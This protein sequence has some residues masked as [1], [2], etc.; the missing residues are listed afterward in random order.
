MK[1]V[2]VIKFNKDLENREIPMPEVGS[3]DVLIKVRAAGICHSDIHQSEGVRDINL[4]YSPGHEIA[5]E[6][7]GLG[8]NVSE[9]QIGQRVC[10]HYVTS[11]GKCHYCKIGM[12]NFCSNEYGVVGMTRNG[13]YAEFVSVPS[14]LVINLPDSV[15]YE[16]GAVM[17]CSTATSYHALKKTRYQAGETIAIFGVGGVGISAIQLAKALGAMDIFA[18]DIDPKKLAFAESIGA[19]PINAN[20]SDPVQQ[21]MKL[22]QNKGVNV[23]LEMIGLPLTMEQ[24]LKSLAVFGRLGLVGIT[25]KFWQVNPLDNILDREKEIIGV[26][27]HLLTDIPFVLKLADKGKL[28]LS[29]VVTKTVPLE[30]G[31][32]NEVFRNLKQ[33]KSDFRTVI[34]P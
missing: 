34:K 22:T 20:D 9:F 28:D 1:A 26:S 25:P 29:R 10:V 7:T 24:G 5:G 2:Q 23:A 11:C 31:P 19:H 33:Y 4:P 15:S 30:A 27:D 12:D 17:C 14:R 3:S 18:V 13:G 32:I 16:H 21:I 6:I 8:K